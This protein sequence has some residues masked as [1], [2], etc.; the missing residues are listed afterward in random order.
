MRQVRNIIL[1]LVL[2]LV[3]SGCTEYGYRLNELYG[4]NCRPE[5]LQNGRCVAT[6]QAGK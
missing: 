5:A 1:L 3:L 2:V 4:L 6:T